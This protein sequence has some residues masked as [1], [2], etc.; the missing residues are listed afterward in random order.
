ME[1]ATAMARTP[2]DRAG[3]PRP[4]ISS[5]LSSASGMPRYPREMLREW[6]TA[7]SLRFSTRESDVYDLIDA[8]FFASLASNP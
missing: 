4:L 6:L 3:K 1:S 7:R 2:G 8:A 5:E